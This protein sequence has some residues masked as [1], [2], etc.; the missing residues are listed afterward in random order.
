MKVCGDIHIIVQQNRSNLP[1]NEL[2]DLKGLT[3]SILDIDDDRYLHAKIFVFE[4]AVGNY[5]FPE[6]RILQNQH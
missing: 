3:Y 4:T 5:I 6:V 2:R 1:V